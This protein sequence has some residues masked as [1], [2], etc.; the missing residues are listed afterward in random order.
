[1]CFTHFFV[2]VGVW[3]SICSPVIQT[4]ILLAVLL[5]RIH[6]LYIHKYYLWSGWYVS[7]GLLG[8]KLQ[9]R[10][11][12]G[13]SNEFS[14]R[15]MIG[16]RVRFLNSWLNLWCKLAEVSFDSSKRKTET[17]LSV[18]GVLIGYLWFKCREVN[19]NGLLTSEGV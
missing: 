4:S 14:F 5:N 12:W 19:G 2:L 3:S 7:F 18:W 8:W 16:F 9:I 13:W 17:L 11:K 1:M 10:M 15:C 6:I